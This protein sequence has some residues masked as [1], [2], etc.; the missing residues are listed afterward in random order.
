MNL[1]EA[2]WLAYSSAAASPFSALSRIAEI[3]SRI[4]MGALIGNVPALTRFLGD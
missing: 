4:S 3:G 2:Q 1:C